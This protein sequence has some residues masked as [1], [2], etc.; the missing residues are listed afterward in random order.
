M[1]QIPVV[2]LEEIPKGLY[3]YTRKDNKIKMCPYFS[4]R[5]DLK[6]DQNS[7]FCVLTGIADWSGEFTL[8]WDQI[9]E[10]NFNIEESEY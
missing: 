9:K 1:I 3:C 5:S 8:I 10:C 2:N 7:G 6:N 4:K